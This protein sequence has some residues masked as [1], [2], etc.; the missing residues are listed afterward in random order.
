MNGAS[1]LVL[2]VLALA[3]VLAVTLA[4]IAIAPYLAVI[5]VGG[6]GVWIW[7]QF[8]ASDPEAKTTVPVE[9]KP[10]E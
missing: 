6:V 2:G 8:S 9:T 7:F 3:C 4:I 1:T 5:F 10:R